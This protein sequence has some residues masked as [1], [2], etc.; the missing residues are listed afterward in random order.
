MSLPILNL[1][2]SPQAA[3][4]ELLKR[5]QAKKSLESSISNPAI[6]EYYARGLRAGAVGGKL[7]GAG[8]GGFLLFYCEP[9]KQDYVRQELAELREE[10]NTRKA[11]WQVEKDAVAK[12]RKLKEQ[13]EQLKA[14]EQRLERTGDLARVAEIRYGKL[15]TAERELAAA[16]KTPQSLLL[17]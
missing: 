1:P 13:I 4:Q 14:E 2:I 16:Q 9:E 3:A 17:K 12:I 11:K 7:L 8:S 10:S 15:G 5:R 6:D